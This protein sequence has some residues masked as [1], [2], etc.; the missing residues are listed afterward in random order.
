MDYEVLCILRALLILTVTM[1]PTLLTTL[2][3]TTREDPEFTTLKLWVSGSLVHYI[4]YIWLQ[5]GFNLSSSSL[6]I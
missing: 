4:S 6:M 3:N 1:H 2:Q 5:L